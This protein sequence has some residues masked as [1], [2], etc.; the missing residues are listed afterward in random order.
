MLIMGDTLLLLKGW[1]DLRS[2][3]MQCWRSVLP[4][5]EEI[6][7]HFQPIYCIPSSRL[8]WTPFQHTGTTLHVEFK[9]IWYK[10]LMGIEKVSNFC[11][12]MRTN[13]KTE[14][15]HQES[16]CWGH[17]LC[18]GTSHIWDWQISIDK[19]ERVHCSVF[20]WKKSI[21]SC[22]SYSKIS[23][24]SLFWRECNDKVYT[25]CG[26]GN[27]PGLPLVEFNLLK[28]AVLDCNPH[29]WHDVITFERKWTSECRPAISRLC[30]KLRYE[31]DTN[32]NYYLSDV[33]TVII[34]LYI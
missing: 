4:W 16:T 31:N 21:W 1:H 14:L 26:R 12:Q 29:L 25:P 23:Y 10:C 30:K 6:Y 33:Y 2:L 20:A 3:V 32:S 18:P 27:Y 13:I 19:Y 9:K 24:R 28:Q 7:L 5:E 11:D 8:S 22:Y 34:M 15:N 17:N